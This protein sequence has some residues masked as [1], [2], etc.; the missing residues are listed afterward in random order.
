MHSCIRVLLVDSLELFEGDMYGFVLGS[1]LR[2]IGRW[3]GIC[4][5]MRWRDTGSICRSKSGSVWMND[6]LVVVW[7]GRGWH[8]AS[9]CRRS[10]LSCCITDKTYLYKLHF[11]FLSSLK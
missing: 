8:C 5:Q 10:A 9:S 11:S 1:L 6:S 4:W 7:V 3:A 2:A